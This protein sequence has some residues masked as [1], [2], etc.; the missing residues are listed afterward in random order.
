MISLPNECTFNIFNNIRTSLFSCLF[1]S[2]QWCRIIVPI[3]WSGTIDLTD[4]RF[5]KIFLL[6]LNAEERALLTPFKINLPNH[7]KPLFEYT[8]YIKS[9]DYHLHNGIKLASS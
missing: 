5:I 9:V 4:K 8:S 6:T 1:V 3:L 2:R 7:P